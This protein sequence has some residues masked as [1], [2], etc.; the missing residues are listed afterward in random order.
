MWKEKPKAAKLHDPPVNGGQV[1]PLA[2]V[3]LAAWVPSGYMSK[4]IGLD[5]VL[6]PTGACLILI[7]IVSWLSLQAFDIADADMCCVCVF[8]DVH[9][10]ARKR[11]RKSDRSYT[12]R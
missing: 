12:K 7:D 8:F 11:T 3:T 9:G 6:F 10:R 5:V 4:P 1:R 2:T